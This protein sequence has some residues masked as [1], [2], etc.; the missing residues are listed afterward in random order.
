LA[1]LSPTID[2]LHERFQLDYCGEGGEYESF[3]VDCPLFPTHR[4]EIVKSKVLYDAEDPSVGNL[5]IIECKLVPKSEP[6][7]ITPTQSTSIA[8]SSSANLSTPSLGFIGRKLSSYSSIASLDPRRRQLLFDAD[9]YCQSPLL[10]PASSSEYSTQQEMVEACLSQLTNLFTQLTQ[11]IGESQPSSSFPL[12]ISD[13]VSSHLYLSD[14]S[15]FETVNS[16]YCSFFAATRYP[17]SR[18]CV[19]VSFSFSSFSL[20]AMLNTDLGPTSTRHFGCDGRHS[21]RW[22]LTYDEI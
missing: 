14:M 7:G 17:P 21:S 19:T 18:I 13:A 1:T 10:Y 2:R 15:L 5:R 8:D 9:G 11:L 12:S 22:L 3:V 20:P 6:V 16:C 4:I